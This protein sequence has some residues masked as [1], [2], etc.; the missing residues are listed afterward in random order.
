MSK[1]VRIGVIGAGGNTRAKHIPGFQAIPGVEVVAVCNRTK[2]SGEKVAKEF[3]I[4]L[5]A[6]NWREI[7]GSA[8][9]DAVCIGTWPNMH[10]KLAVAALREG[11]HVLTEARMARNLAEA[12]MMLA[13]ASLHPGL[14]AQ[15]VPAPMSLPFDSTIIEFL[16]SGSL[17]SIR[18]VVLTCT[19]SGLA[20]SSQPRNWRQDFVFSG[21]N[22]LFLGIYYE[23]T[24]RWLGR[25]VSAL[26]ADAA[27]FTK[28]RKDEDGVPWPITIPESVTVL[29]SY[30]ATNNPAIPLKGA[31]KLAEGARLIAHFSGVERTTPRNEI[32]LNGSKAG[33]RL[34]LAR[35]ELWLTQS[36]GSE[37]L[38]EIAPEKRGAWRVEADFIDSI[39]SGKPVKLT[40]FATGVTY[41]H[42]TDAVW[43][44]WSAFGQRV[45]L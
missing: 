11:K 20:D 33:L 13:E 38:V 14:V 2:E 27:I 19:T 8:D 44:S 43:E 21:K 5:V 16:Q 36:D 3:G 41:M 17:G 10:G 42:F 15:I 18:E 4:P 29:G 6:E 9:V 35:N 31:S 25:G 26:I 32:R 28:E 22:T 30:G 45:T 24:L 7:I 23:M 1:K 40:D 37:N 39:R 34:D 12:E